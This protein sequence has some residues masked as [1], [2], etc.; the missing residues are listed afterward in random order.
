MLLLHLTADPTTKLFEAS[1]FAICSIMC[2][3]GELLQFHAI[4][5]DILEHFY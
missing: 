4:D 5:C 1:L 2:S 3:D